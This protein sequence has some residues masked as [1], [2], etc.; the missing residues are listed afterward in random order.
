MASADSA[1]QRLAFEPRRDAEYILRIQPELLRG[2]K[3]TIQIQ[4][5]PSFSFPVSGKNSKPRPHNIDL[6]RFI[7]FRWGQ[8]G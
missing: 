4:K 6:V 7:I 2:G 3:V 1:Q 8:M 5:V